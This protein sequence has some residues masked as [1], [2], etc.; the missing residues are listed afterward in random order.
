MVPLYLL[1][2]IQL[3][4]VFTNGFQKIGFQPIRHLITN[5]ASPDTDTY[6]EFSFTLLEKF[7]FSRFAI[8]VAAELEEADI[9]P[10]QSYSSLI[11]QINR[12]ARSPDVKSINAKGK[13]ML[14]RLFPRWLLPA[15]KT[16]FGPFMGFNSWMNAYVTKFTTQWLMGPSELKD[17]ERPDGSVGRN[18]LLKVKKCRFLEES[19]CIKTCIHACKVPTQN[20]FM[21]EMGLPVTL[22]P[23]TETMSCEFRFGVAPL[24]LEEDQILQSK[25]KKASRLRSILYMVRYSQNIVNCTS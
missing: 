8:S 19:G 11:D 13:S 12:M 25:S 21:E 1:I 17:L 3:E 6:D 18:L 24:S 10:A 22:A 7:L 2:V 20:F 16:L 14:V 15:Y 4:I 5:Y 9:Q 23:D